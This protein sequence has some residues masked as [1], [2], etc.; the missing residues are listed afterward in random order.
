MW[1][2][3]ESNRPCPYLRR[4]VSTILLLSDFHT[5]TSRIRLATVVF[6]RLPRL[7]IIHGVAWPHAKIRI[8]SHRFW[9]SVIRATDDQLL[10]AG[11]RDRRGSK[12]EMI[13]GVKVPP[14]EIGEGSQVKVRRSMCICGVLRLDSAGRVRRRLLPFSHCQS[15]F[16]MA[17]NVGLSDIPCRQTF[18]A[19][20]TLPAFIFVLARPVSAPHVPDLF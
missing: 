4:S 12:V 16:E 19:E 15:V 6:V 14:G 10:H 8:N 18:V 9:E 5:K 2:T 1:R 20:S 17:C 7:L 11:C 3:R 13:A